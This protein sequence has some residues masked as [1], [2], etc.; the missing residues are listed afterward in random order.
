M[1]GTGRKADPEMIGHMRH[2][3]GSGIGKITAI[4]KDRS[5]RHALYLINE[6]NRS[7]NDPERFLQQSDH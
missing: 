6:K 5:G 1:I 7:G 4:S 2:Y 3:R